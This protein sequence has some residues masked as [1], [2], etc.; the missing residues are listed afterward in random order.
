VSGHADAPAASRRAPR[1]VLALVPLLLA[2]SCPAFI[3][4]HVEAGPAGPTA[5][6]LRFSYERTPLRKVDSLTV[7]ACPQRAVYGAGYDS[8]LLQLPVRWRITRETPADA[9]AEPLRVIYGRLPAG[10]REEAPA[11][12]LAVGGCYHARVVARLDS[13]LAKP[14]KWFDVDGGQTFRLLPDGRLIVGSPE[15]T[16]FD[17]RPLRETNR[18]AVACARGYRRARTTADS[19]AVDAREHLI[20]EHPLSCGWLRAHWPDVLNGPQ[21]TERTLLGALGLA[22]GIVAAVLSGTESDE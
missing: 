10:Y 1:L 2:T 16:F 20:L 3:S 15:G 17:R 11:A 12:P 9:A 5:P 21:T 6:E 7:Y 8:A 19:A 18:A 4:V 22:I 14:L 13:A